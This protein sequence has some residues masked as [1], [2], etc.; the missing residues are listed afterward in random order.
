[1]AEWQLGMPGHVPGLWSC[2][3]ASPERED[4][5]EMEGGELR[6]SAPAAGVVV[7]LLDVCVGGPAWEHGDSGIAEVHNVPSLSCVVAMAPYGT[8][9]TS[10]PC[11][12]DMRLREESVSMDWATV[13]L[14]ERKI[15]SVPLCIW[16]F[17]WNLICPATPRACVDADF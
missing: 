16:F 12:L 6:S 17:A 13:R 11:G 4:T 2:Y 10:F 15:H 3:P 5:L 7:G 14:L 1:V 9:G 8:Q